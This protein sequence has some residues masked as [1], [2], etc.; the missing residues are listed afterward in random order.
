MSKGQHAVWCGYQ[1]L[2]L[3]SQ[4]LPINEP[5]LRVTTCACVLTATPASALTSVTGTAG[6]GATGRG[7][8]ILARTKHT[9]HYSSHK[10]LEKDNNKEERGTNGTETANQVEITCLTS[11]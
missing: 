9:P 8:T 3:P 4:Y 11:P 5:L 2:S 7:F 6:V 1:W 10:M